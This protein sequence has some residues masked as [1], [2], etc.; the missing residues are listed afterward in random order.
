MSRKLMYRVT[1]EEC[2]HLAWSLKPIAPRDLVVRADG[3]AFVVGFTVEEYM[4]VSEYDPAYD[5]VAVLPNA[6]VIDRINWEDF[7]NE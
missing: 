7:Y 6:I 1:D 4:T 5:V 2:R 3:I